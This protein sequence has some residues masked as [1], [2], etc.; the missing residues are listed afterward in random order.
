[1]KKPKFIDAILLAFI[2]TCVVFVA[3]ALVAEIFF[4]SAGNVKTCKVELYLDPELTTK[5]TQINWGLI[6]PNSTT[7]KT[8]YIYNPST[9]SL[10]LSFYVSD[11]QPSNAPQVLSVG[12]NL[13]GRTLAPN[14]TKTV[15]L[16]LT[17]AADT[18]N[19]TNFSNMLHFVGN[20]IL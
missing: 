17:C 20:E 10:T 3:G 18:Q 14:E 11:W 4:P 13:E 9:V 12:W 1:M 5:P 7:T 6:D 2:I 8:L 19:V 15:I 16:T